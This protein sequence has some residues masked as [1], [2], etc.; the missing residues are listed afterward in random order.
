MLK[1]MQLTKLFFLQ[2]EYKFHNPSAYSHEEVRS[3]TTFPARTSPSDRCALNSSSFTPYNIPCQPP[4][5]KKVTCF[6]LPSIS[7]HGFLYC[8]FI[9]LFLMKVGNL[10]KYQHQE[11]TLNSTIERITKSPPGFLS[12]PIIWTKDLTE[13]LSNSGPSTVT[14]LCIA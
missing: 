7:P 2:G 12:S 14:R 5:K 10:I 6:S 11:G 9:F 1:H 3:L 4:Q 13:E 8:F